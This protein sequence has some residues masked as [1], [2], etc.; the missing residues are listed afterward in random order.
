MVSGRVMR[1]RKLAWRA[2]LWI[3]RRR[4]QEVPRVSTAE[5]ASWLADPARLA[6]TL[7][8]AREAE[9]FAVSH[10][11][12]AV[13]ADPRS[14]GREASEKCPPGRAV[15]VYCS[16]GYRSAILARRLIGAGTPAVYNLEGSI[17]AWANEGRPLEANGVPVKT[18][19][20][21]NRA[22][23]ILLSPGLAARVG[24]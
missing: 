5:L 11:A 12:G 2:I 4:F 14:S 22:G 10:L 1:W 23:A 13:W 19:H 3:V 18:A 15:V 7:L 9:E 21:Y 20:P 6:P 16:A 24:R 17:F 8:D